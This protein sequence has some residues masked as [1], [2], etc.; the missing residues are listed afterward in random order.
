M[1]KQFLFVKKEVKMIGK[2]LDVI[3][4]IGRQVMKCEVLNRFSFVVLVYFVVYGSMD[5]GEIVF[6][7]DL[8]RLFLEI[9]KEDFILII[10][11]VLNV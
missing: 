9:M 2:I 7:F 10:G 11:E 1:F 6:I 8:E 4:F 5:I 3:L